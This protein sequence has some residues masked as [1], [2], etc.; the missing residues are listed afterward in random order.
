MQTHTCNTILSVQHC[1]RL[2]EKKTAEIERINHYNF[3]RSEFK[4]NATAYRVS[5]IAN[6]KETK[7]QKETTTK[8]IH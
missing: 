8:S 6:R 1:F 2:N 5:R 3:D 7:D 4:F